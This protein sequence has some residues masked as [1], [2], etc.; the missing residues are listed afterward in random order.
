MMLLKKS[1]KSEVEMPNQPNYLVKWK[2]HG[3]NRMLNNESA[4]F[5]E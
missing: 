3:L 1:P 4:I 2:N 5:K